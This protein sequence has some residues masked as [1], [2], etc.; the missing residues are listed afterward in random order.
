MSQKTVET[1]KQW[2]ADNIT[3]EIRLGGMADYVGYSP[4]YCSVKFH[5]AVGMTYRQYHTQLKLERAK[6]ELENRQEKMID[7]AVKYG[8][9]SHEAFSRAFRKTYGMAPSRYRRYYME[10][11]ADVSEDDES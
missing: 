10:K 9:H 11:E 8:F 3:K 4:Y 1:M 5:E 7:I 2:I 6:K